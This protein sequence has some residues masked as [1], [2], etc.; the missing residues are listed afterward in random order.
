MEHVV[1]Y[2]STQ[3][4]PAFRRMASIEDA[5]TFAE[6]LRNVEGVTD[7]SVYALTPVSLKL[8]AYYHV[9]ISEAAARAQAQPAPVAGVETAPPAEAP[10][11]PAAPE[12]P[13][14]PSFPPA[15][16]PSTTNAE[17]AAPEPAMPPPAAP[18]A[19]DRYAIPAEV[20]AP[21]EVAASDQAAAADEPVP[22]ELPP[23]EAMPF[24]AG[25][26]ATRFAQTDSFVKDEPNEPTGTDFTAPADHSVVDPTVEEVVPV[27]PGRRSMGFFARP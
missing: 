5:V 7:F 6:H 27:T 9:E 3:G 24:I 25:P 19:A 13:P 2:Q 17:S 26:T 4:T 20:A 22:G 18:P 23:A 14:L 8:R 11:V 21:E 16:I 12:P 10:A 1:F 15:S